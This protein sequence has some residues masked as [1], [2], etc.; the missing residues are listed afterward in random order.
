MITTVS[1]Y[2]FKKRLYFVLGAVTVI[3]GTFQ[4]SDFLKK[5]EEIQTQL[6]LFFPT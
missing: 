3:S 5:S 6:I 1:L 2:I 4:V